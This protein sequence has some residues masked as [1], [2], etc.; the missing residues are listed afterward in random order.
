MASVAKE[1]FPVATRCP[2]SA[3]MILQTSTSFFLLTR[4]EY[5][6]ALC[7]AALYLGANTVGLLR[8]V[9]LIS[10]LQRSHR[11]TDGFCVADCGTDDASFMLQHS[12]AQQQQTQ[13]LQPVD[14]RPTNK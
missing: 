6:Q 10:C 9:S 5:Q 1:E 14:E 2:I 12:A 11:Q 8:G 4:F 3:V 7:P 13:P